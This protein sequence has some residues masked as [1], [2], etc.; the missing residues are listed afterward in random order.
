MF[1]RV[2]FF[3]ILTTFKHVYILSDEH[4]GLKCDS[5]S[6]DQRGEVGGKAAGWWGP[7]AL[8]RPAHNASFSQGPAHLLPLPP[9]SAP[10]L[11]GSLCLVR[12]GWEGGTGEQGGS[13]P[14]M[15]SLGTSCRLSDD[16]SKQRQRLQLE[17]IVQCC[18]ERQR[19][20]AAEG[21]SGSRGPRSGQDSF[22]LWSLY[23]S[24]GDLNTKSCS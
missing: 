20:G 22:T 13:P 24:L 1:E 23:K 10:F 18:P 11:T 16:Q 15:F 21:R 4:H 17:Q 8:M 19:D 9:G 12:A 3:R 14:P 5:A 2:I 6:S 7:S